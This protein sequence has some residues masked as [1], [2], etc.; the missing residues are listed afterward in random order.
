MTRKSKQLLLEAYDRRRD[1]YREQFEVC[2]GEFSEEAVHDLRVA[3]RRVLAVYDVLRD[4]EP[5]PAVQNAR[6]D[7]KDQLDQLDDLR[8][9]QVML[10]ELTETAPHL[11]E[12]IEFQPYLEKREKRLLRAARKEIRAS[13][14]SDL[15]RRSEKIR[16][17]VVKKNGGKYTA[18]RLLQAADNAYARAVQVYKQ[19][20]AK[21]PSQIH[22]ARIAFKRFRY[23]AEIVWP[24]VPGTPESQLKKMQDYQSM[25]GE[26]GDLAIF[27]S[28]LADF[29]EEKKGSRNLP[30]VRRHFEKRYAEAV[31]AFLRRTAEMKTFWRSAP[32]RKFPWEKSHE[33]VRRQARHR[34]AVG[35]RQQRGGQP[36]PADG[37]GPQADAPD[38][39]GPQRAG[40][41]ARPYPDEPIPAS[42]PDSPHP[43][44]GV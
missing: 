30:A 2:R 4:L 38:Q 18:G 1:D 17:L 20:L 40:N 14:P 37:E 36:A 31:A 13:K 23:M 24:L 3:A 27:L 35:T 21:N 43:G 26:I 15:R 33:P 9:S 28:A 5:Q 12:V 44:E 6:R 41:P 8:D 39:P 29:A 16:R 19:N 34:R 32:D 25:M 7:L 11:P 42:D 22:Q 10:V